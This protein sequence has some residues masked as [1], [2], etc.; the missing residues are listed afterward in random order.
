MKPALSRNKIALLYVAAWL[1]MIVLCALEFLQNHIAA[2][3]LVAILY[4]TSYIGPAIVV[5]AAAWQVARRVPWRKLNWPKFI[6]VE[7]VI[8]CSFVVFWHV[9]FWGWIWMVA[10]RKNAIAN[11]YALRGWPMLM[12]LLVVSMHAAVFHIARIFAAL[13]EKEL[14]AVEAESLRTRAEMQA[15]RGQLNPHFLFNSLHSITALVRED[16]RRAEDALLQFSALLRRVLDVQRD[17]S[18]EV[19]LA[20]EMKFVDD[21]LAIERLRLGERLRVSCELSPD[22]LACWLPAFSV[23]PLVENAL[24][25]AIAPRRDGGNLAIRGAVR[26]GHLEISV[27]DDGPGAEL[28]RVAHA[29][30]VGLSVVRQRLKL[31][32]GRDAKLTINT[33]P[34][35]GFRVTLSLP[36]ETAELVGGS[37]AR[38]SLV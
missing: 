35:R 31:R 36:A 25:Y 9:L 7:I 38:T 29:K 26:H 21:Y 11:V 17:S 8:G 1:P 6:G 28:E 4:S 37:E 18:D 16:P 13:R 19:T 15:L 23:Q 5:G 24:H 14:A 34:G 10:G 22:A 3:A 33:E 2:T 27:N 32:Y 12:A 30:G 20:N